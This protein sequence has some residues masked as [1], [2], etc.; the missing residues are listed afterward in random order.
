[1]FT[2]ISACR[3]DSGQIRRPDSRRESTLGNNMKKR[4]FT[5]L[6]FDYLESMRA[7]SPLLT[8]LHGMSF[9]IALPCFIAMSLHEFERYPAFKDLQMYAGIL[10]YVDTCRGRHCSNI[11]TISTEEGELNFIRGFDSKTAPLISAL[12]GKPVLLG[13]KELSFWQ[14]INFVDKRDVM[15]LVVDGKAFVDYR[16][17][18]RRVDQYGWIFRDILLFSGVVVVINIWIAR[19]EIKRIKLI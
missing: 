9:L 3:A 5:S 17:I 10:K 6:I 11:V 7:R 4:S 13:T 1:M 14:K 8:F 15:H 2:A 19:R 18:K 12:I 16:D